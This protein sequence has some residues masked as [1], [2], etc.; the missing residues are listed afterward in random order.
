MK[1]S[2]SWQL[3]LL[4][5]AL[6]LILLAFFPSLSLLIDYLNFTLLIALGFLWLGTEHKN[7]IL[8]CIGLA[9]SALYLNQVLPYNRID[10]NIAPLFFGLIVL[11]IAIHSILKKRNYQ[12]L[13]DFQANQ[14]TVI[15]NDADFLNLDASFSEQYE[16]SNASAL[17]AVTIKAVFGKAVVDLSG[18]QFEKDITYV[19]IKQTASTT[20]L[21]LPR[22]VQVVNGLKSSFGE[23]QV[24][25]QTSQT[26]QQIYLT[27]SNTFSTLAIHYVD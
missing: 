13:V 8:F 23:V 12:K 4:I 7:A 2:Y 3:L 25:T 11:G 5:L 24:P 18:A 19:S 14:S 27:G 1:K 9:F 26:S 10:F 16:Y 6:Y 17:K 21:R 22:R 20:I 15:S